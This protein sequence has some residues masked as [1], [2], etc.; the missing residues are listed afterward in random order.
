MDC[1]IIVTD[2]PYPRQQYQG[3]GGYPQQP[4]NYHAIPHSAL[5]SI[6][7]EIVPLIGGFPRFWG[8]F[9]QF[10]DFPR[11]VIKGWGDGGWPLVK[12]YSHHYDQIDV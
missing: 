3:A 9:R 2:G 4:G 10:C 1:I 11:Y 5:A 8:H 12:L 7:D 6:R